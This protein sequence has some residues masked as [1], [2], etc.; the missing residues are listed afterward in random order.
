MKPGIS[1]GGEIRCCLLSD[2][3]AV[4]S[5]LSG[6]GDVTHIFYSA[7]YWGKNAFEEVGPNLA[8]LTNLVETVE[9]ASKHSGSSPT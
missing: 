4:E 7:L 9:H 8:M 5:Q 1:N 2:R 6:I 3:S